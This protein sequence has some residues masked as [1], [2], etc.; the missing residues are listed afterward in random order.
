MEKLRKLGDELD[1]YTL[2]T[3][4]QSR[5]PYRPKGITETRS[6]HVLRRKEG[7]VVE[8]KLY[9]RRWARIFDSSL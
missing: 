8:R 6:S 5:L 1:L 7:S 2:C 4:A 9:S 3:G